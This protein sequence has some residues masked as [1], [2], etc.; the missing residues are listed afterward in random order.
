MTKSIALA[1]LKGGVADDAGT[2]KAG[3][4]ELVDRH[5]YLEEIE[6]VMEKDTILILKN[7]LNS[8]RDIGDKKQV[9]SILSLIIKLFPKK[10]NEQLKAL[11]GLIKRTNSY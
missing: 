6:S 2:V 3:V 10:T 8:N 11:F 9:L 7:V 4:L 5:N 1:K